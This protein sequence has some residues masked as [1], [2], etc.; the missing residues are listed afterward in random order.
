[1]TSLS[2]GQTTQ[3]QSQ[4]MSSPSSP[5]DNRLPHVDSQI[6]RGRVGDERHLPGF[7]SHLVA[8]NVDPY[9]LA[10]RQVAVR[11]RVYSNH[12]DQLIRDISSEFHDSEYLSSNHTQTRNRWRASGVEMEDV[13]EL[14]YIARGITRE[15]G[16]IDKRTV[17][18]TTS[19]F[20]SARNTMSLLLHRYTLATQP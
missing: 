18:G 9:P 2:E 17:T 4:Q 15:R 3:V 19:K 12:I 16:N 13:V 1:M 6:V 8:D 5:K 10:F 7:R 11:P 14:L 20:R